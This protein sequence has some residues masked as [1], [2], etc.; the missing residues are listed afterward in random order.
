MNRRF[1]AS[2]LKDIKRIKS[3]RMKASLGRKIDRAKI[4]ESISDIGDCK[5]LRGHHNAFRIRLGEYRIGFFLD[6]ETI[7]FSRCLHRKEIYHMFP[8]KS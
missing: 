7:I 8:P 2:F 1:E 6:G 3:A 4:A 5:K